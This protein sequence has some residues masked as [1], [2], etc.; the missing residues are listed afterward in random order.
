[1][2]SFAVV[3]VGTGIGSGV[4]FQGRPCQTK[5]AGSEFGHMLVDL[6]QLRDESDP[7]SF[8]TVEGFASGT[9]LIRR[10]QKLGFTGQSVEE[11]I[12]LK[13]RKFDFLFEDMA[14][15]L[16]V[17]CYNLSVGFNLDGI[18][19]SG[20]LIK[21][22][23]YFFKSMTTHYQKLIRGFNQSFEC[24]IKIARARNQAGVLGAAYLPWNEKIKAQT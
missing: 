22:Q 17:L 3:T 5:G 14:W 7:Q 24:P 10:A 18:F 2:N 12:A 19:L 16:S 15:A 8:S 21:I 9:G 6:T 13:G 1:M 23:N 20:G 11:L 4:I